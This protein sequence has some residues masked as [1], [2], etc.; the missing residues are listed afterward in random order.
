MQDIR[1]RISPPVK[2]LHKDIRNLSVKKDKLEPVD[3]LHAGF[4]CQR[5]PQ[6]GASKGFD[7]ERGKNHF[8][9]IIRIVNEFKATKTKNSSS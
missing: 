3:V 9:E 2:L 1:F 7:D 4:P 5:L 8:Y 6:A